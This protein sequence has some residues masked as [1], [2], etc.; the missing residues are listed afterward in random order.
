MQFV[1]L[2]QALDISLIAFV[3]TGG[4]RR[5]Q[6]ATIQVAAYVFCVLNRLY[7][8]TFRGIKVTR[9]QFE[10][11]EGESDRSFSNRVVGIAKVVQRGEVI[12]AR[13][14]DLS[15]PLIDFANEASDLGRVGWIRPFFI[16]CRKRKQV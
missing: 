15:L 10:T 12:P 8:V 11:S 1:H 14:L 9:V 5:R 2:H 16:D 6:H 4:E 13:E 3:N 7:E